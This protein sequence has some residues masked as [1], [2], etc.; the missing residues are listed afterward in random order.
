VCARQKSGKPYASRGQYLVELATERLTGVVTEHF[1]TAAM[2]WGTDH[3]PAARAAFELLY[4]VQVEPVGWVD[5]PTI[6][7][8]GATPDGKAGQWLVEFKC[9]TSF[10]HVETLLAGEI[11]PRYMAQMDFQLACCPWAAGAMF[12]SYDPRLPAHLRLWMARWPRDEE[13]IAV[14]EHD[15]NEFLD[16]LADTVGALREPRAEVAA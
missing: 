3:E 11:P 14:L 7:G 9:P 2:Q 1:V 5:H 10:T 16:E 15:I 13:R 8:A 6:D 4:N 12:A